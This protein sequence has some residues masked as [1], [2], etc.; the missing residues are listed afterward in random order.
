MI[1]L[2]LINPTFDV[3]KKLTHLC[4]PISALFA[5]RSGLIAQG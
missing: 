4:S 1:R 5:S 2:F 3:L